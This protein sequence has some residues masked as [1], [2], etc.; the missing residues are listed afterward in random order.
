MDEIP[1][2]RKTAAELEALSHE[3]REA[4]CD[5][6]LAELKRVHKEFSG[7]LSKSDSNDPPVPGC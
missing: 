3:E 6:L 2:K 5:A 4:Y 7:R 1:F